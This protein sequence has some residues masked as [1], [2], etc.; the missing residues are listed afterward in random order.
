MFGDPPHGTITQPALAQ[1]FE[2]PTITRE[3]EEIIEGATAATS[4]VDAAAAAALSPPLD[5]RWPSSTTEAQTSAA[6][7]R[8]DATA[9]SGLPVTC[10]DRSPGAFVGT[11]LLGS[12]ISLE[13]ADKFQRFPLPVSMVYVVC[14]KTGTKNVIIL[15]ILAH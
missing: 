4:V 5:S 11:F 3:P 10:S 1:K 8:A 15:I 12:E 9:Y 2:H 13:F 14:S 7:P 6:L